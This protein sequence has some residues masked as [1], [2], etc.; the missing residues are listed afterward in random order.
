MCCIRIINLYII[1]FLTGKNKNLVF[2]WSRLK[3]VNAIF[4]PFIIVSLLSGLFAQKAL[5]NTFNW[6]Y[7]YHLSRSHRSWDMTDWPVSVN[8]FWSNFS[9]PY[10][11]PESTQNLTF[12]E[13]F[14]HGIQQPHQK[15]FKSVLVMSDFKN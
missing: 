1:H 12:G 8:A 13:N 6:V 3:G 15:S 5:S 14:F 4:E 2:E 7:I 9:D 11:G 10:F